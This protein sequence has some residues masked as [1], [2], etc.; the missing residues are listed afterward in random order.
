MDVNTDGVDKAYKAL[1]KNA[2]CDAKNSETVTVDTGDLRTVLMA[3][4]ILFN[5][6]YPD[7]SST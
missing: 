2:L 5:A 1:S 3:F 7:E 6:K 4:T